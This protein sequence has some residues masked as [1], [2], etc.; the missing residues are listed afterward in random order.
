MSWFKGQLLHSTFLL[1]SMQRSFKAL[2]RD[3]MNTLHSKL[4][5]LVLQIIDE[6]SMVVAGMLKEVHK[7]TSYYSRNAKQSLHIS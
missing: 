1:G 2:S 3:Q 4:S 6:V 7:S 5:K